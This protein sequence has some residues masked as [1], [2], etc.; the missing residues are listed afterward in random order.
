MVIRICFRVRGNVTR[1]MMMVNTRMLTPKLA[2]KRAY[3][4]TRMF[5]IGPMIIWFHT[6][7]TSSSTF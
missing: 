5:I 1:R 3:S 7:A 4:S 6:A 2:K